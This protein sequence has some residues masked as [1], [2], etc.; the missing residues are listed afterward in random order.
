MALGL[1]SLLSS[2]N[3]KKIEA[4]EAEEQIRLAR[5]EEDKR[6]I[7]E[8]FK[9]IREQEKKEQNLALNKNHVTVVCLALGE[10]KVWHDFHHHTTTKTKCPSP[11]P[12]VDVAIALS[13]LQKSGTYQYYIFHELDDEYDA[14][15]P[16]PWKKFATPTTQKS[17]AHSFNHPTRRD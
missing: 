1:V 2:I 7:A 13:K 9:A 6:I 8:K 10:E 15:A 14:D 3:E 4:I 17:I 11:Q 16:Q 5:K 12:R